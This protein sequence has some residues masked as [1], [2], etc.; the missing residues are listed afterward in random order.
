[1]K[2]QIIILAMTL[3]LGLNLNAQVG[4][5]STSSKNDAYFTSNFSEF[6][7]GTSSS[8]SWI[9][10]M[11]ML[12]GHAYETNQSADNAPLGSGLL[13]LAGLGIAYGVRKKHNQ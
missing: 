11:P 3:A 5:Y 9:N 13:L 2:K 6:R 12:L 1:M 7:Q 8:E 10:E 4:S